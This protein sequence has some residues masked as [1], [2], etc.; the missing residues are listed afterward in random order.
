[1]KTEETIAATDEAMFSGFNEHEYNRWFALMK[2]IKELPFCAKT[3]LS[4]RGTLMSTIRRASPSTC[5]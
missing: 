5:A 3:M 2:Q 1:M 4:S